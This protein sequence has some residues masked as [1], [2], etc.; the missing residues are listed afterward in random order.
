MH[1]NKNK[2]SKSKIKDTTTKFEIDPTK[3]IT[4]F[5]NSS[6]H[7]FRQTIAL[8]FSTIVSTRI[9]SSNQNCGEREKCSNLKNK[10]HPQNSD[11]KFLMHACMYVPWPE[12]SFKNPKSY[13]KLPTTLRRHR[14]L[15]LQVANFL[16]LVSILAWIFIHKQPPNSS[17]M[18]SN[19]HHHHHH[20]HPWPTT[21]NLKAILSFFLSFKEV[22]YLLVVAVPG[23]LST[24]KNSTTISKK[25]ICLA[26][27]TLLFPSFVCFWLTQH[28]T[29]T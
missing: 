10:T 29:P 13:T 8:K 23:D 12:I 15:F 24:Q 2:E 28:K 11:T 3:I 5:W 9:H 18:K 1:K 25:K 17:L 16:L 21:R 20:H 7:Y 26:I 19:Y 27:H 22:C 4:S 6:L 14:V